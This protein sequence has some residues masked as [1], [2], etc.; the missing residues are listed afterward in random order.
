MDRARLLNQLKE[1]EGYRREAYWDVKQYSY[2]YGCRAPMAGA[3]ITEPDAAK[4][5][6]QKMEEAIGDFERIFRQHLHK[7]NDVRAE[8]FVNLIFN[9]GPGRPGGN[10]GLLSFKNTLAHITS[11]KEVPWEAVA[12]GLKAS[13]WYRQ[14][15]D[16]GAFP[17]RGNRIVAEVA[18]GI[19][20]V[21]HG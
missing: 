9:M 7:F 3:M 8:A 4:L 19:K 14:V 21:R 10:Q 18:T 1:D 16:S 6:A 2:G 12:K 15:A 20:G 13:L 11:N 17:G 5:L